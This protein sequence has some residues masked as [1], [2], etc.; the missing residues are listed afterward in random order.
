VLGLKV[1]ATIKILKKKKERKKCHPFQPSFLGD[2]NSA[3]LIGKKK[4]KKK[5]GVCHHA[6]PRPLY[7]HVVL[8]EVQLMKE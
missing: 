3:Y 8:P 7:N 6:G 5:K 4:K 1:C 2:K